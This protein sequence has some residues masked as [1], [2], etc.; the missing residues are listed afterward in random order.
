MDFLLYPSVKK[1]I[2]GVAWA[3]ICIQGLSLIVILLAVMEVSIV[4]ALGGE[5]SFFLSFIQPLNY[6]LS[7]FF[8]SG[9]GLLLP[10]CHSVLLAQRGHEFTRYFSILASFFAIII[11]ISTSYSL[12]MGKAL[13]ASQDTAPIYLAVIIITCGLMNLDSMRAA[14]IRQRLQIN[15]IAPLSLMIIPLSE[16]GEPFISNIL[17]IALFFVTY[18]LLKL[19][20]QSAPNIV[21][22]PPLEEEN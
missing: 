16:V 19:L 3:C 21:Q 9:I 11:L 22:L 15:L 14:S 7:L 5:K 6:I 18:P 8:I 4:L 1:S 2:A 17:R 12:I 10:W 13:L 20:A